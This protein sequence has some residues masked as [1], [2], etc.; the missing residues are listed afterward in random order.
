[1]VSMMIEQSRKGARGP[2]DDTTVTEVRRGPKVNIT[3]LK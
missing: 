1:M 3:V 2:Q